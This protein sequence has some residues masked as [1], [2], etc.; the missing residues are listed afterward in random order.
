MKKY[1]QILNGKA[2][3]I[4]ESETVPQFAP[5]IVLVEIPLASPVKE[6]WL[7]NNVTGEFT[8]PTPPMPPDGIIPKTVEEIA[9]E[10]QE[11]QAWDTL[12]KFD[13]MATVFEDLHANDLIKFQVLAE[14]YEKLEEIESKVN[15]GE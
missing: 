15:G 6:G 10:I 1:V 14:M 12:V 5:N 4:F 11:K 13:A 9:R 7:Y 3:W 2:H 8:A